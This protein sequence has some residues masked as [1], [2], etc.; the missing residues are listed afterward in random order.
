MNSARAQKLNKTIVDDY[1]KKVEQI[2][3][4]LDMKS[5]PQNSN[6]RRQTLKAGI[7]EQPTTW[8]YRYNGTKRKYDESVVHEFVRHLARLKCM[9]PANIISGFSATGP[10]AFNSEAIPEYASAPSITTERPAPAEDQD[11]R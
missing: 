1:F 10:Y 5:N 11:M 4:E 2:I 7:V 6:L 9:T 8:K 3:N